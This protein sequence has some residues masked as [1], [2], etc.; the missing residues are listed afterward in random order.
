MSLDEETNN[1][2]IYIIGGVII[3]SIIFIIVSVVVYYLVS[4][5]ENT[6]SSSTTHNHHTSLFTPASI[7]IAIDENNRR[8]TEA[9]E[10][11]EAEGLGGIVDF[12]KPPGIDITSVEIETEEGNKTVTICNNE[13]YRPL[14]FN[15]HLTCSNN[16]NLMSSSDKTTYCCSY[17][18]IDQL[19][20]PE[21]NFLTQHLSEFMKYTHDPENFQSTVIMGL[22][23]TDLM[24]YGVCKR[25]LKSLGTTAK[26]ALKPL[27]GNMVG[28]RASAFTS[29]MNKFNIMNKLKKDG[30]GPI[31]RLKAALKKG[32]EEG[33]EKASGKTLKEFGEKGA[34][35][36]L[37]I[38]FKGLTKSLGVFMNIEMLFEFVGWFLQQY[39]YGGFKQYQDNRTTILQQR[40]FLQGM[41]LSNFRSFGVEAPLYFNLHNIIS[42]IESLESASGTPSEYTPSVCPD[43]NTTESALLRQTKINI[44]KDISETY[45]AAFVSYHNS[46]GGF[47]KDLQDNTLLT[48]ARFLDNGD[49]LPADYLDMVTP[50]INDNPPERDHSIWEFLKKNL[51]KELNMDGTSPKY[52][53]FY[54]NF[55]SKNCIGI[56]LNQSGANILNSINDSY[57]VVITKYYRDIKETLQLSTSAA[58]EVGVDKMFVLE[59]KVLS[60]NEEF[61]LTEYSTPTIEIYC[62]EGMNP[63]K[64]PG[65]EMREKNGKNFSFLGLDKPEGQIHP[66]NF[67]TGY[68]KDTGVCNYNQAWCSHMGL[69]E[70]KNEIMPGI[71]EKNIYTNCEIGLGEE[72]LEMLLPELAVQGIIRSTG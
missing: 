53:K 58:A 48:I 50:H 7:Q 19:S 31:S 36:F 46:L 61:P 62:T 2:Q 39:D 26:L 66:C 14:Y 47:K 45:K 60:Q 32:L 38:G 49:E 30:I 20:D 43:N 24:S 63:E 29:A 10:L 3:F 6:N 71:P 11:L 25:V 41:V 18:D 51:N 22:I 37:K 52:I 67:T 40:D 34:G 8:I 27:L 59:Q 1:T 9:Q 21:T 33:F 15:K 42:T 70:I 68:N 65:K 35:K 64:L 56:S 54:D 12:S 72:M 5:T 13:V 17:D 44:L 23:V 16:M 55:S 69:S 57:S 4:D 28:H